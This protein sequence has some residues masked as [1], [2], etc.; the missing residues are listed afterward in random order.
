LLSS[1]ATTS[2]PEVDPGGTPKERLRIDI[3]GDSS[4]ECLIK[5]QGSRALP[6]LKQ[7]EAEMTANEP[8]SLAGEAVVV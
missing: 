5:V 8:K 2:L 6:A 4:L 1:V 7:W 3:P